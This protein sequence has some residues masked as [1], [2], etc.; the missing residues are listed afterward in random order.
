MKHKKKR[1]VGSGRKKGSYSFLQVS[2]ADLNDT[3]KDTATVLVSR[4]WAE[5]IGL[6]GQVFV[7]NA[8]AMESATGKA[9]AKPEDNAPVEMKLTEW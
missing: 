5:Q 3:L 7:A 1:K 8:Q 4:K 6:S 2:L 9:A